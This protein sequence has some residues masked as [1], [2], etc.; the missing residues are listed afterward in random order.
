MRV[1]QIYRTESD[2]LALVENHGQRVT[3][4]YAGQPDEAQ[5]LEDAER[6]FEAGTDDVPPIDVDEATTLED[7]IVI[8]RDQVVAASALASTEPELADVAAA[9]DDVA[10]SLSSAERLT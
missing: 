8:V 1:V 6:V 10:A 2:W 3:L 7:K 5:V 4:S 9:L